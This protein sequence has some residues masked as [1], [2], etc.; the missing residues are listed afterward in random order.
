MKEP[1]K[2]ALVFYWCCT[3]FTWAKSCVLL[4]EPSVHCKCLISPQHRWGQLIFSTI[5]S[6]C[7]Q[8]F[9]FIFHSWNIQF[10]LFV[11][12]LDIC[13]GA[14]PVARRTTQLPSCRA[15]LPDD[16]FHKTY[17]VCFSSTQK[18]TFIYSIPIQF[19]WVSLTYNGMSSRHIIFWQVSWAQVGFSGRHCELFYQARSLSLW[20]EAAHIVLLVEP[21]SLG[22]ADAMIVRASGWMTVTKTCPNFHVRIY[23]VD[24]G[25]LNIKFI[26]YFAVSLDI[27]PPFFAR[28]RCNITINILGCLFL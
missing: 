10:H 11:S 16:M 2:N 5:N 6:E 9:Q 20:G 26:L 8:K 1:D 22:C 13:W 21:M 14:I 23:S 17:T 15:H 28:S 27:F 19:I 25:I 18:H 7:Q 24:W 12:R 4:T 3:H